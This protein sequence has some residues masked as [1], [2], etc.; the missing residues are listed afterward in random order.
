MAYVAYILLS[1]YL[2]SVIINLVAF[3]VT[4]LNLMS[5]KSL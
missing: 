5:V 4:L 1:F 2:F 3:F